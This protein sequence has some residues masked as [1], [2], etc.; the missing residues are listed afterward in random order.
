MSD[1]TPTELADERAR[2]DELTRAVQGQLDRLATPTLVVDLD[3]VEH[4]VAAVLRRVGEPSRWR[5]HVKTVKQTTIVGIVLDAGVHRFKAAT[6]AEVTLVLEAAADRALPRPVDVLLAHPP[7]PPQLHAMLALRR[8]HPRARIG[9][10]ADSPQHLAA[11]VDGI[12]T[13]AELPAFDLWLD[14]D[15]GM[16]R[17][18]SLPDVWR[19]TPSW[20]WPA[21]CPRPC[22]S[23]APRAPTA[24]PTRWPTRAWPPRP[25]IT[26]SARAPWC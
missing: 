19:T 13:P 21:P 23:C 5:P 6:P 1:P 10:L 22:D 16:H 4:N 12:G 9:L 25:G 26:R 3:A 14:V 15:L 18:G 17:T 20:S 24:M 7:A 2:R 8:A 11:L